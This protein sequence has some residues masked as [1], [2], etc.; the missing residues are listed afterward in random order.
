M[1]LENSEIKMDKSWKLE[2]VPAAEDVIW[3]HVVFDRLEHPHADI[4]DCLAH[5]LLP[6]FPHWMTEERNK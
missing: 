2:E 5:P 6:K 4:G 1:L 3:V